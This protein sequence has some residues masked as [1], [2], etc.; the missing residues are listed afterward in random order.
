M[1]SLNSLIPRLATGL[2][3]L[4]MMVI[5]AGHY[6][7]AD[8]V[9]AVFSRGSGPNQ[10]GYIEAGED[11]L[12]IGAAAIAVHDN[13]VLVLDRV[14]NRVMTWNMPNKKAKA[15]DLGDLGDPVDLLAIEG[16][17]FVFD[18]AS[19]TK[20]LVGRIDDLLAGKTG[21]AEANV[22]DEISTFAAGAFFHDGWVP[23][24]VL[25]EGTPELDGA[26]I[27]GLEP[28]AT[29]GPT[30]QVIGLDGKAYIARFVPS[31]L[32]PEQATRYRGELVYAPAASPGLTEK[33][34][35]ER[36]ANVNSVRLLSVLSDR[37]YVLI[38]E[39]VP[40]W[41]IHRSVL[42]YERS[43]SALTQFELPKQGKADITGRSVA[44]DSS[45]RVLALSVSHEGTSILAL[46]G[47]QPSDIDPGVAPRPVTP[48]APTRGGA[49]E[50][51]S[52]SQAVSRLDVMQ[53][54]AQA[55][56]LTWRVP[57]STMLK[58]SKCDPPNGAF[59]MRPKKLIREEQEITGLPYCWGCADTIDSFLNSLEQ[60][61]VTGNICTKRDCPQC[62]QPNITIG[63]DCS[64]FISTVWS[65]KSRVTT[66]SL[67]SIA[68]PL[69]SLQSLR[70]GDVLNKSGSHVRLFVTRVRTQSGEQVVIYES[71]VTCS[72][73]CMRTIDWGDLEGYLPFRRKNLAE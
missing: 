65:L 69:P 18:A 26:V 19:Y 28:A 40:N 44:I 36:S 67:P 9:I 71:S 33:L 72:G 45:G 14:N 12:D 5:S 15:I 63:T 32:Q 10:I 24:D 57:N 34:A 20:H 38:A 64:G 27:G 6:A 62:V 1:S 47:A 70:Q 2:L 53:M 35:I 43:G 60:G 48:T 54:A 49:A 25:I 7:R 11:A 8:E 31:P 51:N 46:T 30:Q 59:W 58:V 16:N 56:Q 41:G 61:K 42:A 55:A 37:I 13:T 68:E 17:L 3:S 21:A 73:V 66:I 52:T 22:P 29:A 4:A 50:V 39:S 23:R